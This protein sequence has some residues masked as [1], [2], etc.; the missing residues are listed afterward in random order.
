M[1]IKLNEK[2]CK[3]RTPSYNKLTVKLNTLMLEFY[4]VLTKDQFQTL[5]SKAI[6]GNLKTKFTPEIMRHSAIYWFRRNNL[7][8][9]TRLITRA[10][11]I[12]SAV[13]KDEGKHTHETYI[14]L[15]VWQALIST[16]SKDYK[17]S[18]EQMNKAKEIARIPT[19]YG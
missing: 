14:K 16:K 10:I 13:L 11:E 5:K 18:E 8:E 15:Y 2:A 4:Q 9:A 3:A 7:K 1:A 6:T 12:N 17:S 19:N